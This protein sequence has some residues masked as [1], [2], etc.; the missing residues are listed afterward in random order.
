MKLRDPLRGPDEYS[1][2]ALRIGAGLDTQ[3]YAQWKQR[4][5]IDATI[6]ADGAGT[7]SS[8]TF[9]DIAKV[10]LIIELNNYGIRMQKGKRVA[11]EIISHVAEWQ[12]HNTTGG[13]WPIIYVNCRNK[14]IQVAFEDNIMTH[15]AIRLN[16]DIILSNACGRI[17]EM[18]SEER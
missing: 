2:K 12:R 13:Q 5:V 17:E 6:D 1:P 16:L 11:S 15:S 3:K 18:P 10:A 7:K 14:D 9:T 4:G 8:Y